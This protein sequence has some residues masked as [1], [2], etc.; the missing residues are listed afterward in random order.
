MRWSSS[1][2]TLCI[3][4]SCAV[5]L[6]REGQLLLLVVPRDLLSTAQGR[7]PDMGRARGGH[8]DADGSIGL[9]PAADAFQPVAQM[10]VGS[11]V[12]GF[13]IGLGLGPPAP[14]GAVELRPAP[15]AILF[16]ES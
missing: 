11:L 7:V 6:F 1:G 14:L 4:R 8:A 9:L 13:D 5:L 16:V 12:L 10:V 3:P 2:L 15:A